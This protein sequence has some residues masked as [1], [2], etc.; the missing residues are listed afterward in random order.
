MRYAFIKEPAPLGGMIVYV[1]R[2]RTDIP[3]GVEAE[4]ALSSITATDPRIEW[5]RR[6]GECRK[7]CDTLPRTPALCDCDAMIQARL[8]VREIDR[9]AGEAQVTRD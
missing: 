5:V 4:A 3:S 7:G 2:L 1:A 8:M 9:M 6:A